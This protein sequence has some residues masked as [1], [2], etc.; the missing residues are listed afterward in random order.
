MTCYRIAGQEFSFPGLTI[1]ELSFFAI[2]NPDQ[3]ALTPDPGPLALSCQ[4]VGWVGEAEREVE[5][6]SARNG[7]LL[8]VRGGSDFFI[9]ADGSCI[10]K[11]GPQELAGLDRDILLGPVLVLALALRGIWCLHASAVMCKSGLIVFLGESGQGKS[12]LAAYLSSI[13]GR[14]VADDILPI[15][16]GSRGMQV[17]PHF[18]QLKLPTHVQPAEKFPEQLPLDQICVLS[19]ADMDEMPELQLLPAGQAVQSLLR[20]TA[21]TRLFDSALLSGHLSFCANIGRQILFSQLVY[22]HRNDALPIVKELLED[23]C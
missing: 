7:T 2:K 10:S 12:T 13:D 9:S 23:I 5:V 15:T 1:P 18:P 11:A 6:W 20:H 16:L 19:R 4:T 14:L 17:W 21:G 8:K 3:T 22:P